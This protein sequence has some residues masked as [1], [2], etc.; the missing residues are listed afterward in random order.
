MVNLGYIIH[1]YVHV[2][3]YIFIYISIIVPLLHSSVSAY[4]KL[5][6]LNYSINTWENIDGQLFSSITLFLHVRH[7]VDF[8]KM[9]SLMGRHI[10]YLTFV[11]SQTGC[12]M[13]NLLRQETPRNKQFSSVAHRGLGKV[14]G[15]SACHGCTVLTNISRC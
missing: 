6:S 8:Q 13:K 11:P 14:S 3:I 1:S 10:S 7:K 15:T 5:I 4:E 12:H 9:L 2:Y